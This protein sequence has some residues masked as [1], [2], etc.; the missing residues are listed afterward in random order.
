[1]H[2]MIKSTPNSYHLRII[3]TR[4]INIYLRWRASSMTKRDLSSILSL[5]GKSKEKGRFRPLN[6]YSKT[7]K[8]LSEYKNNN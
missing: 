6:I 7:L 8:V 4:L 1:M 3:L 2:S 5:R